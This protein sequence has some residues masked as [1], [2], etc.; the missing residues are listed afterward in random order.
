MS[1]HLTGPSTISAHFVRGALK[2]LE[3]HGTTS[4]LRLGEIV[5]KAGISSQMLNS[6]KGRI[7]A[8]AF[9]LLIKMLWEESRDEFLN[10][11]AKPMKLGSLAT[12]CQL[13][14]GAST[15]KQA[16]LRCVRFQ[17]LLELSPK[18]TLQEQDD[19]IHLILEDEYQN[20]VDRAFLYE[21]LLPTYHR[22]CSWLIGSSLT[23]KHVYFSY[24]EPKYAEEYSVLFKCPIQFSSSFT[25]FVFNAND[26]NKEV[27]KSN[28]DLR[29]FFEYGPKAIFAAPEYDES[30][31][32]RIRIILSKREYDT[33]PTFEEI[34]VL[35]SITPQTLR[36]RLKKEG[37]SY[38]LLKEDYRR[39]LSVYLLTKQKLAIKDI[40]EKLGFTETSAF[41]RAFKDWTGITPAEYR[42]K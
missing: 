8:E 12:M 4:K 24:N 5:L 1:A 9:S 11:G 25:G 38:K 37:A 35:F 10:L 36:R 41:Q 23:V 2:G 32:G 28:P 27:V 7:N 39:D 26:G 18:I 21:A 42:N 22:F 16:L 33:F 14:I 40:S 30:Y 13:A 20:D 15:L 19:D 3:R 17:N 29:Q 34:A 31:V 6:D